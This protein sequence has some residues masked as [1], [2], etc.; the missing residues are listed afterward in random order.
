MSITSW[1]LIEFVSRLLEPRER[2]AVL[3][4]LIESGDG[5]L[6]G[7]LGV[8][9]LAARRQ[10]LL[11]KSWRPWF[12]ALVTWPVSHLLLFVTVSVSCTYQRLILHK[13]FAWP[14]PTGNEGIFLFLCHI[15]LTL[16]WSWSA[17][18]IVGS[19]SRRTVWVSALLCVKVTLFSY[20]DFQEGLLPRL[21]LLLF[22]I[23]A[24]LGAKY[25]L[26]DGKIKFSTALLLAL[27]VT[28]SMISAWS[29]A[30]LWSHNWPLILPPWF[31]VAAAYKENI[32]TGAAPPLSP[33]RAC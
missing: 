28:I 20:P 2:E 8:I 5:A 25:A 16:A 29:N 23:P 31:L 22:F 11:W 19:I 32:S 4:D 14:S 18:F 7:L 10:S 6:Q 27:T 3:G 15:F 9:G 17:G 24:V 1:S 33:Q 21:S 26:Q 30:A 13:P 12:A